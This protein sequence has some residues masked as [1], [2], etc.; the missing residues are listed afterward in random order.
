LKSD[1]F[2]LNHILPLIQKPGRYLGTEFHAV[3]KDPDTLKLRVALVFPDLYEIGMSHL[4][5]ELLYHILN[6]HDDI[7]A[8]RVYAPALDLEEA[9]RKL[10]Q[11]LAS[12]ESGT[13]L[14]TF[15]LL[16]VSLQYELSYTNLLTILELGGITAIAAFRRQEEPVVIGGGPICCNP[17]PVAPFFDA[18]LIGDG[19][20]AVIEIAHVIRDWRETKGSRKE[21]YQTLEMVE[22]VYVPALFDMEYD[23]EGYVREIIPRGRRQHIRR[24][25]LADL[26]S[27]ALFPRPLVPQV[28]IVHDRL[29]V[30]ICRGC[31][32]GCRFCQAGI[33]YR[34][35][36]ERAPETIIAWA[37]EAL[38]ASG[39]EEI[40]LLSLS[41]GDYGCLSP[42]LTGLMDRLE[43]RRIA[44]SLPSMRADTLRGNLMEQIKRVRKTGFT[45]APEA[46]S[47]RLRRAINKNLTEAEIFGTVR[48]AF[49]LGWNLLKL[50]FM[51]GFPMEEAA[52]L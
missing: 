10:G 12:L 33:I 28:Q 1:N 42:L 23:Q 19:E 50:Y 31:T 29:N 13:P 6:Q 43:K 27:P 21:L 15:D 45:I 14:H 52:D 3:Y 37:E 26:D 36:R 9:L 46:G 2:S 22:G 24:R 49:E 18:I 16:G 34:P 8:E 39:F 35:V 5:L 4:G 7:W 44:L 20:E 17:E 38:T 11:P 48:Q 32:R 51:I 40:S 47:E 41:T 30:E 25:V